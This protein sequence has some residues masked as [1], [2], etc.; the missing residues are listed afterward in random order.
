VTAP[1]IGSTNRTEEPY[2][3]EAREFLREIIIGK[4]CEFIPEYQYGGRDYGTLI[5]DG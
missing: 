1:K 2:G 4:K 5:V 3:F